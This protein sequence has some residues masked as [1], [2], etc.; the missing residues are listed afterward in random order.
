LH[1]AADNRQDA[2]IAKAAEAAI[3]TRSRANNDYKIARSR[4]DRGRAF[5]D[6]KMINPPYDGNGEAVLQHTP[7]CSTFLE[8][9]N[10]KYFSPRSLGRFTLCA[11]GPFAETP[12]PLQLSKPQVD[13]RPVVQVLKDRVLPVHSALI[14]ALQVLSVRGCVRINRPDSGK[15]TL[16]SHGGGRWISM[17][18]PTVFTSM[19]LSRAITVNPF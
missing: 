7:V 17:L 4:Y 13:G 19:M 5:G 2:D 16:L 10:E 11:T 12:M 18:L 14:S 3:S 6:Q 1:R 9:D 8:D 15:R